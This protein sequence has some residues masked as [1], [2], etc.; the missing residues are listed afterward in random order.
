MADGSWHIGI[1]GG[2]GLYE[3]DELEEVQHLSVKSTF[4]APSGSV[5][6]GRIGNVRFSFIARHGVGHTNPTEPCQLS[7]KY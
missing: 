7:R 1:L 3:L 5:T 4:G 6:M 2:S